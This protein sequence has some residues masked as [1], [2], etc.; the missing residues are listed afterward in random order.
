LELQ[1]R[2]KKQVLVVSMFLLQYSSP[3]LESTNQAKGFLDAP[4]SPLIP[5]ELDSMPIG[6]N[7]MYE[8]NVT[9]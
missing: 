8:L 6:Q 2:R 4:C 5:K 3:T 1:E 7:I 9:Y